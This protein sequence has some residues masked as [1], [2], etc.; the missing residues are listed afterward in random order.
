[1]KTNKTSNQLKK[2]MA[3]CACALGIAA[4]SAAQA[5]S[6]APDGLA[7]WYRAGSLGLSNG[8]SVSSWTDLSGNGNTLTAYG[9]GITYQTNVLNSQPAVQFTGGGYFNNA[10]MTG[11]SGT[12][13]EMF[14][15]LTNVAGGTVAD[16]GSSED[17]RNNEAIF[18]YYYG[19][20]CYHETS[21]G[22]YTYIRHQTSPGTSPYILEGVFGNSAV[23]LMSYVDGAASDYSQSLGQGYGPVY[24]YTSE[25]RQ[26]TVGALDTYLSGDIAELLVYDTTLTPEQEQQTGHYLQSEYNI[27]GNYSVPEPSTWAMLAAGAASLL[28][29][30]RRSRK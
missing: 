14:A 10:S 29:L 24:N 11:L 28:A 9:S 16:I 18:G 12:S 7:A 6:P 17:I 27:A 8:Q 15:V 21:L 25:T 13:F 5:Q 30:R 3:A 23:D 4:G 2:I 19:I 1:M 20:D 26:L 22:G